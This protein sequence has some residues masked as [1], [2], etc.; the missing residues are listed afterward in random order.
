MKSNATHKG[1]MTTRLTQ[2]INKQ[3]DNRLAIIF[4]LN[5]RGGRAEAEKEKRNGRRR[6]N[7]STET[8]LKM[9]ARSINSYSSTA[10]YDRGR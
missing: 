5:A 10:E 6:R 9:I 2:K 7:L 4:I 3:L 1:L 8:H